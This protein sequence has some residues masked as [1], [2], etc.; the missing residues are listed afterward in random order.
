[1]LNRNLDTLEA[2]VD[3]EV[4]PRI[5]ELSSV[6]ARLVSAAQAAR[7]Q[8][9]RLDAAFASRVGGLQRQID[10]TIGRFGEAAEDAAHRMGEPGSRSAARAPRPGPTTLC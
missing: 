7:A 6:A 9:I 3:R 4:R 2:Q 10:R 5:E 1:L 8:S